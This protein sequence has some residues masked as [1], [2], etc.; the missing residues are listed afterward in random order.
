MRRY[1]AISQR[2][3]SSKT[4][5]GL[6]D[7]SAYARDLIIR[8][9]AIA[10]GDDDNFGAGECLA[11]C[12]AS[13][14]S[15]GSSDVENIHITAN[16]Q[17]FKSEA[18]S[19]LRSFYVSKVGTENHEDIIGVL[20]SAAYIILLNY[21]GDSMEIKK[22]IHFAEYALAI[23]EAQ[24]SKYNRKNSAETEFHICKVLGLTYGE[25]ALEVE[26]IKK[27]ELYQK[28][29]VGIL[30]RATHLRKNCWS[31][32]FQLS[33]QLSEMGKVVQA[34]KVL[35][36]CLSLKP[37]TPAPWNLM[38]ILLSI[39]REFEKA[40]YSCEL[41]VRECIKAY[42]RSDTRRPTISSQQSMR[43]DEYA[44]LNRYSN[45]YPIIKEDIF[46]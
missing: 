42:T 32:K 14:K 45:I 13:C 38:A 44:S 29:A 35:K 18:I 9:G 28:L 7:I 24:V 6:L 33:L 11:D 39:S 5:S 8:M 20:I 21:C 26:D 41:G 4:D 3:V 15:A 22:A 43:S 36:S 17:S 40:I 1:S 16:D 25:Y 23:F 46:W 2:R 31:T 19:K 37:T 10:P 27:R 12:S 34:T 30:Q